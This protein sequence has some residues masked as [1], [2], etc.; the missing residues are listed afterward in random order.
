MNSQLKIFFKKKMEK[1]ARLKSKNMLDTS[2]FHKKDPLYDV[3]TKNKLGLL[4]SEFPKS[5]IGQFV[6]LAAKCYSLKLIPYHMFKVTKDIKK[7]SDNLCKKV[8]VI[9]YYH[10]DINSAI[11]NVDLTHT[12][13]EDNLKLFLF[14]LI[15]LPKLKLETYYT[16]KIRFREYVEIFQN[17]TKP[18]QRLP[19]SESFYDDNIFVDIKEKCNKVTK[20]IY[21]LEIDGNFDIY[22]YKYDNNFTVRPY[23]DK[24]IMSDAELLSLKSKTCKGIPYHLSSKMNHDHY[25]KALDQPVDNIDTIKY[26]MIK[27]NGYQPQTIT[28]KKIGLRNF[29]P[30][31][32][33]FNSNMSLSHGNSKIPP[34]NRLGFLMSDSESDSLSDID[35]EDDV[36]IEINVND[37]TSD[38]NSDNEIENNNNNKYTEKINPFYL[39]RAKQYSNLFKN[40]DVNYVDNVNINQCINSTEDDDVNSYVT[41]RKRPIVIDSDDSNDSTDSNEECEFFS[42]QKKLRLIGQSCINDLNNPNDVYKASTSSSSKNDFNLSLENKTP[43]SK[44]QILNPYII[45]EADETNSQSLSE[46]ESGDCDTGSS[47]LSF[48]NDDDDDDTPISFYHNL[49]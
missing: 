3:T 21:F 4:K 30:K 38:D 13:Y 49:P 24:T 27:I 23:R 1:L 5:V 6:G 47:I 18:V 34:E 35:S 42:P 15:K 46:S 37:T 39:R 7:F 40:K 29:D 33:H 17:Q 41:K 14:I 9:T 12:K 43:T 16:S 20:F 28:A 22:I 45:H 32:F 48:I 10:S 44:K 31:R 36:D 26:K 19:T 2:N 11:F 25:L 8:D